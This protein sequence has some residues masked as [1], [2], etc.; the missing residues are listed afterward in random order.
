MT[1]FKDL[2]NSYMEAVDKPQSVDWG[3]YYATETLTVDELAQLRAQFETRL[4]VQPEELF[5]PVTFGGVKLVHTGH[6]SLWP[7]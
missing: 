2:L 4:A 6:S 1:T 5:K 3:L 7:D